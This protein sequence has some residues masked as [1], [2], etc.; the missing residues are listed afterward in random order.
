MALVLTE[1]LR[2][3]LKSPMGLLIEGDVESIMDRLLPVIRNKRII[4]V[5][6]VVS[7]NLI[8]HGIYPELVI[9][10][11]RNLRAEIDDCIECDNTVTVENPQSEITGELWVAIERLF[12]DKTKRFKKILVEGEEDLAVMPAVLHGDGDTVVLYG[13]PDRGIVIIEVTEQKK[14]EISDYLNEMEGDLWN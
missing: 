13:Q 10:D 5:G 1:D 8:D 7:Q 12:M 2:L 11:G 4:S 14:R 9:V 6:D 3:K